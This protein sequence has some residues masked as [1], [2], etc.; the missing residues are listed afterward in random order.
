MKLLRRFLIWGVAAALVA[1][2]VAAAGAYLVY[3]ATA[4]SNVGELT[5]ANRLSIPPLL[6]SEKDPQGRKV[7]DLRLQA[8][9]AE[10][11]AGKSTPTWGVNG[12]YLAPVLRA[13]RGDEVLIN[14]RNDLED[15]ATTLHWH[16]MDLPAAMDGGPHQLIRPGETWPATWTIDQPA[17]TLWF[18][19]H[20]HGSTADHV[21]RG[22]VGMFIID[23]EAS[24]AL[25]LPSAYGVDDIPLIVQDKAFNDDGSLS[26]RRPM[27][28]SFGPLGDEILVNGTHDPYFE[29][30]T[31]LVRFRILNSS[32]VRTYD[33]GFTDGRSFRVI[34]TD[35]GLLRKAV[36]TGRI[37]ISPGERAEIVVSFSPGETATLRSFGADLGQDFLSERLS[38]ADDTFD[39]LQVRATA[40]LAES[41]PLP[42]RLADW[43]EPDIASVAATPS[44]RLSGSSSINGKRMDMQRIDHVVRAGSTEIWEVES[45]GGAH[46]FH[47]HLVRFLILDIDGESPPPLLSGWKDTVQLMPG[48][49]YR[50]LMTFAEYADP[51]APF[52]FHCHVLQH[53]DNGMMGQFIVID[54][55]DEPPGTVPSPRPEHDSDD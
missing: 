24:G 21:Y 46:N 17:A 18:H 41:P 8:G 29:A 33:F 4:T 22:I 49:R 38:G 9:E 27:F 11:I 43:E 44:F 25:P 23:D 40:S 55:G 42:E 37:Q 32:P 28:A 6:K 13:S 47:V 5:F 26:E 35:S 20:P 16:G 1:G 50:L 53:E 30:T 34:A 39:I 10:L 7:F 3:T 54:E 2:G 31:S 15:E 48:K 52:M 14:V 51:T 36:E 45:G 12:P 19:P